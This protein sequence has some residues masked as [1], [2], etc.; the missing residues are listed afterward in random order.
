MVPAFWHIPFMSRSTFVITPDLVLRA[1]RAGMFPMAE[2]REGRRLYW[3]DPEARGIIPLDDFHLPRRLRRTVL[4]GRFEV[5]MDRD[6]AGVIAGCAGAAKGRE[7]TWINPEIETLFTSLHH[8]G[9]AH[10]VEC[11]IGGE[12]VGGLYGVALGGAYFGESM[13][14]RVADAS[15][16]ALVHLV[17][18]LRLGGFGLLDTQFV[19][20]HLARFGAR[21]IPRDDYRV[22]LVAALDLPASWP[23]ALA[24]EQVLAEIAKLDESAS[25]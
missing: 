5:S 1:Y 11:R 12:L 16:V 3:L 25:P 19:T 21:E 18:S 7:D 15:K 6:F 23:G 9:H 4:S 24:P 22:R 14:S 8:D 13:F 17:A 10:S 20:P 2:S